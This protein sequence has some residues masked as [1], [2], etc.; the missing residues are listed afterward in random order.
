MELTIDRLTPCLIDAKTEKQVDTVFAK[1]SKRELMELKDWAFDWT[2]PALEHDEIYKLT[3]AGMPVTEGLVAIQYLERDHAVYVHIAESAPHNKGIDKKY[4]G[5][6]G[7]LFAI[8]AQKSIE[9]G[10]G[11]FF[12]MDAKN[13]DLVRHYQKTLGAVWL[14]IPHEYRMVVEEDAAVK[15]LKAYSLEEVSK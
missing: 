12:F 8:A 7:H 13:L 5:V 2:D 1:A 6:G 9:A 10:F 4:I 14:G 15:L 3:A 11:G